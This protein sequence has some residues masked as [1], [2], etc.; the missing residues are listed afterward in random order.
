MQV[1]IRK[2]NIII[3]NIFIVCMKLFSCTSVFC[4]TQG[5]TIYKE[6]LV[7]ESGGHVLHQKHAKSI[8]ENII[9]MLQ[10]VF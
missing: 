6:E 5:S 10:T 3:L 7:F 1:Y 4:L 8:S 9:A 2:I